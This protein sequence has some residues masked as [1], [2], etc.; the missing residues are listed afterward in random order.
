MDETG[1]E[2][3]IPSVIQPARETVTVFEREETFLDHLM[4]FISQHLLN[5]VHLE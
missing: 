5:L 2:E 1:A 4:D 3:Y